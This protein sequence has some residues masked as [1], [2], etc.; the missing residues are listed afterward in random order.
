MAEIKSKMHLSSDMKMIQVSPHLTD[1]YRTLLSTVGT[2][3]VLAHAASE[4][5]LTFAS[6]LRTVSQRS[7][8]GGSVV[9]A[10]VAEWG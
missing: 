7:H 8:D 2:A 9:R 1:G 6:G 4:L 5:K 3:Q 10:I